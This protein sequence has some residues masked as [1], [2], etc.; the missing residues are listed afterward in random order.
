[1][2][3]SAGTGKGDKGD[4][5]SVSQECFDVFGAMIEITA[6]VQGGVADEEEIARYI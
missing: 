6:A 1:M 2:T 4:G 3:D 5:F